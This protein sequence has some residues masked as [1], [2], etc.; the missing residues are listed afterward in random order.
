LNEAAIPRV[1][2]ILVVEDEFLIRQT[3]VEWLREAGYHIVEAGTVEEANRFLNSQEAIDVLFTDI[4]LGGTTDGWDIAEGFRERS[5]ALPVIYCSGY[6]TKPPRIVHG[7][8]FL[9]K[10]YST[11]ELVG[12]CRKLT[13]GLDAREGA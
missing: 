13:K 5:P 1:L 4:R 3:A 11:D 2:T 9:T 10:P 6:M 8:L 12:A 7:G